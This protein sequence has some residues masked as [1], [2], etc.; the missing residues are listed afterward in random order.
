MLLSSSSSS[1]VPFDDDEDGD[2]DDLL[3]VPAVSPRRF[4]PTRRALTPNLDEE[5]E[6]LRASRA[7]GFDDD[8]SDDFAAADGE[9]CIFDDGDDSS[10]SGD[11]ARFEELPQYIFISIAKGMALPQFSFSRSTPTT[12]LA[13]S[14]ARSLTVWRNNSSNNSTTN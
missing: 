2:D 9:A 1:V 5:E 11:N 12:A 3:A 13:Y 6:A 7:L 8:D 10:G 14:L 4:L